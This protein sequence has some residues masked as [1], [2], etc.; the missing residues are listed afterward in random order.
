MANLAEDAAAAFVALNPGV[1]GQHAGVDPIE[2]HQRTGSRFQRLFRFH[3]QR[4]EAPVEADGQ[5]ALRPSRG[6]DGVCQA[7]G[8]DRQRLFA[9][10]M[11]SRAQRARGQGGVGIVPRRDEHGV[12]RGIVDR[13][14]GVGRGL[15]KPNFSLE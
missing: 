3:Q 4:R 2:H 5:D 12:G 9:E 8:F 15:A 7:R 10:H 6:R 14:R 1:R 11:L 13:G